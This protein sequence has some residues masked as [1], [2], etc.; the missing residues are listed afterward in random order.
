MGAPSGLFKGSPK[1]RNLPVAGG[2]V[3]MMRTIGGRMSR[4]VDET[5]AYIKPAG[6]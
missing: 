5:W 6:Q 2:G 3:S 4:R 1:H